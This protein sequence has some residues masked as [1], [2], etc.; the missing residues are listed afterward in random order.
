MSTTED[1]AVRARW[2][3]TLFGIALAVIGL[4][5][6][7][8]GAWLL[9]LGGSWYYLLAGLALLVAGVLYL[10][11]RP[12]AVWVFALTALGTLAWAYWEVGASFW[13]LV[14]R[15]AP[16]LAL[17]F[18]AALVQPRLSQSRS[19]A[20]AYGLAAVLAVGIAAGFGGMLSE[21]GVIEAK[22]APQK[23]QDAAARPLADWTHYGYNA[24][25]TRFVPT[26]QINKE[27]VDALQVAWTYRTGEIAEGASEFQNT[28]SQIGDTVY[29]CT[30]LNKLV[31]LDADSGAER[32]KFDPQV[33]DRKTWNRCRGVG[34][35][36]PAAV[37]QPFAF[38]EDAARQAVAATDE[39]D[40]TVA[41]AEA[42][43]SPA[44]QACA[45]RI[46][47]TTIDARLL[48]IDAD[49]GKL[50]EAFGKGGAV[51]LTTGLGKVDYDGVLWYYLTSAPTVVRNMIILGGWTFDGRS[52]DEPSG[53]IRAYSADT[54]ELIWAWDMGQ[55]EITKLPPEGGQ[56][57]RATPNVWSTPAFDEELGLIYLPTGNQQPDFWG[58]NRPETTEKHSSAVVAL[59]IATGRERWTFQT[60]HHDIW[61]YDVAS[62]PALYDIPDG[63]GGTLPALVQ[64]TKRGQIFLLDRRDGKPLAEVVEKPVPQDVAEGDWVAKTQPYSTGMPALGTE[65]LTERDMWGATFFD[66]LAC[67][68]AFRKLNYQGEFTAPS[69][70]PTLIYPGYYG[71]FNW[72]SAAVDEDRG[73]LFLNDIRIPQVVTLIPHSEIDESKLVAGHG[74][75]S[76]YPMHGTPFV[77][78]HAAFNSPLGIPCN[79]PPWGVFA[80]VDLQSRQLVWQRPAGTLEDVRLHGLNFHLPLP[81]G[82]PTLGG[83]VATA[84][85]LVFYAGTQD[86][87]LRALDIESGK[88]LWKGRLPVGGQASPMTYVSPKSGKQYVVIAAGGARQSPD[89]GD[90]VVAYTLPGTAQ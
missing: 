88:E 69:L 66:Q 78:D 76:T 79:A 53:V 74:V 33:T 65:P 39:A 64:L 60:V 68:I 49:T 86:Y 54:G 83:G 82:M 17:G 34:Y 61:D 48:Q 38:A 35:Y 50:C 52:V 81:V 59:D 1:K 43:G 87:Y 41:P 3:V 20:G 56:Y 57:S 47:M 46:V 63:K 24:A 75:G 16:F 55:P 10:Q 40:A 70:K 29:V 12:A 32:W 15:L 26:E 4:V 8:G 6:T 22:A 77:I 73:Y 36:E 7:G 18:V 72:G 5:L 14:P 31:A 27:N 89:R 9:V 28:P 2:P 80:A 42:A 13:P 84:S 45:R 85:G 51:D 21:H 19:V 30:P 71:G 25:G 58:G 37:S 90:Y 44:A 11:R 62:Q 23:V 67:R